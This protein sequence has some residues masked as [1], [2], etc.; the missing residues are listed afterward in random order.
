MQ[1]RN[2]TRKARTS[3]SI[4]SPN[5]VSSLLLL[6]Q[7]GDILSSYPNNKSFFWIQSDTSNG[8]RDDILYV[9]DPELEKELDALI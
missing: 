7:I 6:G 8:R 1:K 5:S 3:Y 9:E 2:K 4:P